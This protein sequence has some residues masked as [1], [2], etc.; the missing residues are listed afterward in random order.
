[1]EKLAGGVPER[2]KGTGCKPVGS[3]YAGSN[4]A[5]PIARLLGRLG[6]RWQRSQ[7]SGRD[8]LR[9]QGTRASA[10]GAKHLGRYVHWARNVEAAPPRS[11]RGKA[12]AVAAC[13]GPFGSRRSLALRRRPA[14]RL[15][16]CRL[17]S[18]RPPAA[19]AHLLRR[20]PDAGPAGRRLACCL[21]TGRRLARCRA[22][23]R[24]LAGSCLAACCRL[25]PRRLPCRRLPC[26][27]LPCCRLPCC[28]LARRRLAGRRLAGRR[29]ATGCGA[30]LARRGAGLPCCS[31][32]RS[33]HGSPPF[34]SEG[35]RDVSSAKG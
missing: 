12:P 31:L 9:A 4:P 20:A 15:T 21:A 18:G 2:P 6:R 33:R 29:L 22:A 8:P 13:G 23:C 35:W 11:S 7:A 5:S 3:A 30:P 19:P 26:C 1:M 10:R 17:A 25:L 14:G 24:G 27:R 34:A 28:R 16:A 32:T